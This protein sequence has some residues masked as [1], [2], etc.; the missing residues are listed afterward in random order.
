MRGFK[1]L[2]TA[3]AVCAGHGSMRDGFSR[4]GFVWHGPDRRHR[5][6]LQTAWEWL[7]AVL[8]AA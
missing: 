6:R 4:R 1:R 5:P 3:P 7:T 2:H 8:R